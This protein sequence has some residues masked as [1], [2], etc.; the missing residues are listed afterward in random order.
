MAKRMPSSDLQMGT[1]LSIKGRCLV[2]TCLLLATAAAV[3]ALLYSV[4]ASPQHDRIAWIAYLDSA[5]PEPADLVRQHESTDCGPAALKMVFDH[6]GLDEMTL[7]DIETAAAVGPNGTNML[8]LKQIAEGQGLTAQGLRLS[9]DRLAH[10]QMP[11]IAH[12]H[13]DH[14]VLLRSVGK[15]LV[16]DDPSVGRLRMRVEEFDQA[17]DGIVLSFKPVVPPTDSLPGRGG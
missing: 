9:S 11:V 12:V 15:E 14:F 2:A 4:P 17:W 16:V 5:R 10:L 6:Y 1:R 3:A 13:G 8:A 7:E